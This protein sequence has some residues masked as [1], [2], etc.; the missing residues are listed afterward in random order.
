MANVV[1]LHS[2]YGLRPAVLSAA[3]R[4][5]AAGH[6][7]VTPD[8]YA[9]EVA[10]A[11]EDGR[12]IRRRIGTDTLL[13]RAM[14]ATAG[15]P[16]GTVYAGYSMGSGIAEYLAQRDPGAGGIIY[17][18]GYGDAEADPVPTCRA[19]AHNASGDSF[20]VPDEVAAWLRVQG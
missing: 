16:P 12:A 11:V 10:D 3:G 18:H 4:L 5:R 17:L 20:F 8:L 14:A 19:Q 9:G 7:V 15:S 2:I 1:L 6:T 13:A